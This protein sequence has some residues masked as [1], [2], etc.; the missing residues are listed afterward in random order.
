ML[1]VQNFRERFVHEFELGAIETERGRKFQLL[2]RA[3]FDQ[4]L[5]QLAVMI[6]VVWV[7][8]NRLLEI[9]DHREMADSRWEL[10]IFQPFA[11]RL[12]RPRYFHENEELLRIGVLRLVQDDAIIFLTDAF[13][14][15][16][17][18]QQFRGERDLIGISDRAACESKVAVIAL[19]FR[20]HTRCA[21][22]RPITQRAKRFP[23]ATDKLSFGRRARRPR[24][25]LVALLPAI[26]PIAQLS[27]RFWNIFGLCCLDR[28]FNFA[29]IAFRTAFFGRRRA[30]IV[31][32][33]ACELHQLSRL[34]QT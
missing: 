29:E 3:R 15:I 34:H 1:I 5:V 16:R 30:E 20:G 2:G 25:E 28:R 27:F 13:C 26:D 4:R 21:R 17:N 23:P 18:A 12:W 10:S 32:L 14:N 7:A 33:I 8:I 9:A 22:A 6:E 19:H 24:R 11:G 31:I